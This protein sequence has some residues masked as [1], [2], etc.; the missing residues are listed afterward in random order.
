MTLTVAKALP[1]VTVPYLLGLT[2]AD[3]GRARSAQ[4]GLDAERRSRVIKHVNP[5]VRR[6]GD[7]AAAERRHLGGRRGSSVT[8]GIEQLRR[9]PVGPTGP[10][11]GTTS[12]DRTDR[13]RHDRTRAGRPRAT[14]AT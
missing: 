8:I 6:P 11:D 13:R 14:G 4:L 7:L 5:A 3:G 9:R 2:V 12:A 10:T 1:N